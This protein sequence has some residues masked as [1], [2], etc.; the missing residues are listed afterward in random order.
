MAHPPLVVLVTGASSGIGQSIANY[1]G[2][3]GCLVYGTARNPESYVQPELYTLLA[4]DVQQSSTIE[5]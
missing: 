1:L 3:K 4:L 2:Q 5:S